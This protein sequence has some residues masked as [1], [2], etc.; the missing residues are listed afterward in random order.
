[1]QQTISPEDILKAQ[2][3]LREFMNQYTNCADPT[4]SAARKERFRLSE[5]QGEFEQAAYNMALS[6]LTNRDIHISS[7][8]PRTS[9]L[10]RIELSAHIEDSVP[11]NDQRP[12]ALD[13][14]GPSSL[15][16]VPVDPVMPTTAPL[17]KRLGRPPGTKSQTAPKLGV[18]TAIRK[19]RRVA[20]SKGSPK[21]RTPAAKA[22]K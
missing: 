21:R 13:R 20:H 14:L 12:S 9:A 1:M 15:Q 10:E 16:L 6:N 17:K 18:T 8:A 11:T 4:E 19:P 2:H 7:P 3:E 5:E 22:T